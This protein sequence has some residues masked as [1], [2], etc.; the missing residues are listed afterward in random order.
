MT[1]ALQK[2]DQEK[3]FDEWIEVRILYDNKLKRLKSSQLQLNE[4]K[5][6]EQELKDLRMKISGIQNA[7]ARFGD[8]FLDVY[9]AE[10][11][12][13]LSEADIIYLREEIREVRSWLESITGY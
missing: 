3:L 7:I 1:A 11:I 10:L 12:K 13:P 9:D 5:N 2:N 6:L 4:R 8:S